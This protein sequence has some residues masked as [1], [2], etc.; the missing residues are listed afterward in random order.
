MGI[1][2]ILRLEECV[3]MCV[4]VREANDTGWAGEATS[5]KRSLFPRL[6]CKTVSER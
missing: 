4:G 2:L 5:D 1:I 6:V 3:C